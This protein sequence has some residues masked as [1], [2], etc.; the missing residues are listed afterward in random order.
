MKFKKPGDANLAKDHNQIIR[1]IR[2]LQ[3]KVSDSVWSHPFANKPHPWRAS[4]NGNDTIKIAKGGVIHWT[5]DGDGVPFTAV[6]T[7]STETDITVTSA[8]GTIYAVVAMSEIP[9]NDYLDTWFGATSITIEYDPTFTG[10]NLYMPICEVSLTGGIA[11]V[12]V[13][14]L[15]D[16]FQM[17]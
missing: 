8:S 6:F 5:P 16:H 7:A 11:K 1:E 10:T 9:V 12:E 14:I 15:Y 17:K 4:A 3:A 2:R 13:Q